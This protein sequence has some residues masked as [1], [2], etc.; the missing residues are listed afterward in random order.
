MKKHLSYLYIIYSLLTVNVS[1]NTVLFS[2]YINHKD[3][4]HNENNFI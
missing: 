4:D 1:Q 3:F 2:M